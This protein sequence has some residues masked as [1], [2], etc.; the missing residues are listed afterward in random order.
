VSRTATRAPLAAYLVLGAALLA[1]HLLVLSHGEW[2]SDSWIHLGAI[3]ELAERPLDPREP[4]TG[5]DVSFPYYSPWTM[6]LALAAR[7]TGASPQAVLAVGG[8]AG[9][10][11][12]LW[13]L[14]RFV[15]RVSGARWAPAA[16]LV[17]SLTVWGPGPYALSGFLSLD[18]FS[19]G[20]TWPS[21]TATALW[22]LLWPEVWPPSPRG[23]G[24]ATGPG[25]RPRYDGTG[26]PRPWVLLALPGLV[27]LVH[28]FTFVC[29]A[30]TVGVTA[31]L[32]LPPREVVRVAALAAVSVGAAA[33]WPWVHLPDLLGSP[34][35]FDVQHRSFYAQ[36]GAKLGL[37]L[38]ALPALLL[39]LARDRR[40][41]LGWSAVAGAAAWAVGGLASVQSLGRVVPVVA[42][43]GQVAVGVAVAELVERRSRTGEGREWPLPGLVA[44]A[45]AGVLAVLLGMP[46]QA[47][48]WSRMR[49]D[50]DARADRT[51]PLH[52][53]DPYPELG[54]VWDVV[55]P[56]DVAVS[57]SFK[58]QRQLSAHGVRTV[59]PPWPSP[60]VRDTA[61]RAAA[62]RAIF[63]EGTQNAVRADLLRRYHVDWVLWP[64]TSTRPPW[65]DRVG[66][67]TDCGASMVPVRV[68]ATQPFPCRPDA[69]PVGAAGVGAAG[70][71]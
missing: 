58:V 67:P 55:R 25:P 4:Q 15:T 39:R 46:A 13:A 41:P 28:P 23:F 63:A 30:V 36:V 71:G 64:A 5:E 37:L 66:A 43:S 60:A 29:A 68:G 48:V 16:V 33:L 26:R 9:P 12:Y 49:L 8:T 2:V 70:V 65:L 52:Y 69:V 3:R 42:L 21:V 14:H 50:G 17:A 1:F 56:G 20:S 57:P 34:E 44:A 24:S 27:L 45:A 59:D 18:T 53:W 31:V 38:L 10:V 22:L 62:N 35:G 7:L 6:L 54:R 11:L 32:R 19:A 40:D 61:A 51:E 47:H